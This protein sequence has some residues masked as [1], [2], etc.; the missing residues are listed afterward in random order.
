VVVGP[1]IVRN[2]AAVGKWGLT[3]EYGSAALIERFAYNDMTLREFL[4]AF[5]YCLPEIGEPVIDRLFGPEAM[6]RFVYYSPK[7]FF[8]VGRAH[9]DKLVEA[10]GRLD[11]QIGGLV[12]EEMRKNWW[13]YLLVSI[14][15]GW[16]GMWVGGLLGLA[17]V[18]LFVVACVVA[19]RRRQPLL[20]FYAAPAV[21]MLGLHAALANQYTRYNLILIGPFAAGAAWMLARMASSFMAKRRSS[22]PAM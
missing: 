18:P 17:L 5:P 19:V 2:H 4:L 1:W 15:L 13:R 7:S 21:V 16:C 9:R 12:R 11:P 10:N 22:Q 3:E 6:E 8:H 14:P 20:L